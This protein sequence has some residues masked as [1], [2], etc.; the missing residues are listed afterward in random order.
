MGNSWSSVVALTSDD[1]DI[2]I[3]Q[4]AQEMSKRGWNLNSM[5]KPPA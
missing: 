5:H 2:D 3:Y 4:V 1:K